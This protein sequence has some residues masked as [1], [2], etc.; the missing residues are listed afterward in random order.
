M[1][2]DDRKTSTDYHRVGELADEFILTSSNTVAG[3]FTPR[4]YSRGYP[5]F[6]ICVGKPNRETLEP[7][8]HISGQP[9]DRLHLP[10]DIIAAF[11]ASHEAWRT[12]PQTQA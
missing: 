8:R 6:T 7:G 9:P 3:Y 4:D 1:I 10:E 12:P 11:K 5:A 2:V